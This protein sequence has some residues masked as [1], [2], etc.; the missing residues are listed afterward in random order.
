M[1]KWNVP[2]T[3]MR[4]YFAGQALIGLAADWEEITRRAGSANVDGSD[5]I[6]EMAYQ[7]ADSM[8]KAREARG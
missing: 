4:D 3:D 7:I 6:A 1:A 2:M 5:L 8:M